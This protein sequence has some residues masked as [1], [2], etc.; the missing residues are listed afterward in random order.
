MGRAV[1][2]KKIFANVAI[3]AINT[4]LLEQ[5][6]CLE[7]SVPTEVRIDNAEFIKYPE[8]KKF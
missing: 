2:E 6:S 4:R 8:N 3:N 7:K 5:S 1:Q